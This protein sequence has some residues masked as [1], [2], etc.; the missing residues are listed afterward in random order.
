VAIRYDRV[1]D[2]IIAITI[3]RPEVRNALDLPHFQALAD[4]WRRFRDD[5]DAWVAV[6]TGVGRSFMAGGDLKAYIPLMTSGQDTTELQRAGTEAVLRGFPL[7]KPVIAAVNG[8]CVAG[9]ME[10]LGA[11]DIRIA[12]PHATFGLMEAKRGLFAGGGSTVRLP[13]QMPYPAAMEFL[14]TAEAL[15]AARA[16]ELG[17]LNEIV[18][19]DVLQDRALEWAHR[20]TANARSPCRRPRRAWCAPSAAGSRMPTRRKP[21]SATASSPPRTRPR[22]RAPSPRSARRCGAG[23][24]YPCAASA[25]RRRSALMRRYPSMSDSLYVTTDLR[26]GR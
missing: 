18:D 11:T 19:E 22:V 4:A 26:S 17:L 2:H 7:Y 8:P 24:D 1:A 25:W 23:A 13:R 21:R 14:L 9:G 5:G 12:T 16:L 15:P 10:L 6:L 3:D 20:I